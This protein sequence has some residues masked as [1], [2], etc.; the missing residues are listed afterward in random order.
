[1]PRVLSQEQCRR[2]AS[3][4]FLFP[5]AVLTAAEV[6]D[7]RAA[8]ATLQE[9][10]GGR[11]KPVDMNQIHLHFRWAYELVTRPRLLDI[12]EDVLGP[13]L[14]V[15]SVSVFAKPPR[16]TSYVSWH[17]DGHYWRLEP[18]D[19]TTAWVALSDSHAENGA[20]RVLPGSHRGRVPHRTQPGDEHNLL[21]SGLTVDGGVDE[22]KVETVVLRAG[23]MSLHHVN[24][25]HGSEAN[26]SA[27]PRIG[28]AIRYT[29]PAVRQGRA[30]HA[31]VLARG[32]DDQGHFKLH[33][34]LPSADLAAG[35]AALKAAR[36]WVGDRQIDDGAAAR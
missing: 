4:G 34:E 22:S 11:P 17:Q 27:E 26:R 21:S 14:L 31:V 6:A 18:P 3:D 7:F 24:T 30:H 32:R 29:T 23:E 13:D 2:Y 33:E 9:S 20:L 19:L 1:M 12:V 35:L 28:I 8:L 15:H 10:L 25:V 36:R 16:D 5:I